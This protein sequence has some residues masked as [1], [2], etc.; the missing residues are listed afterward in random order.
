MAVLVSVQAAVITASFAGSAV[1]NVQHWFHVQHWLAASFLTTG[2]T[3]AALC[4]QII[5]DS[6]PFPG[7]VLPNIE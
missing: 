7:V 2:N 5:H 4:R 6:V 3:F 1:F